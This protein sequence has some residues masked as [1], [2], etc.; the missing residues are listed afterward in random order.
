[1][2]MQLKPV[3]GVYIWCQPMNKEYHQ[4]YQVQ[5]HWERFSVISLIENHRQQG[6]SQYADRHDNCAFRFLRQN[7]EKFRVPHK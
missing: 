6:D 7:W 3:K 4:A 5:P 2:V 1:M